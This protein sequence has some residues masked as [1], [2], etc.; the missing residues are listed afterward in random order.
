MVS[1]S[2]A[3]RITSGEAVVLLARAVPSNTWLK[4]LVRTSTR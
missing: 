4:I 1:V 2:T 3:R